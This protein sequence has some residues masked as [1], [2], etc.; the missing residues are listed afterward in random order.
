MKKNNSTK[1][2]DT[3]KIFNIKLLPK[4]KNESMSNS[5]RRVFKGPVY[6]AYNKD[7]FGSIP[8]S[9]ENVLFKAK[10][11]IE[12]SKI[13]KNSIKIKKDLDVLIEGDN[14]KYSFSSRLPKSCSSVN[15]FESKELFKKKKSKFFGGE[16][17]FDS[18]KSEITKYYPGPGEYDPDN[19]KPLFTSNRYHS[20]FK[21]N[22]D[23]S[24]IFKEKSN[25]GPGSYDPYQND[26]T[27]GKNIIFLKEKKF[28][29]LNGPF[30]IKNNNTRVGPGYINLPSGFQIKRAHHPSYFFMKET[31]GSMSPEDKIYNLTGLN[32]TR[33]RNLIN[34]NNSYGQVL[35][36]KINETKP[37]WIKEE[38]DK[39]MK[40]I[41][42]KQTES[43]NEEQ[44]ELM[45]KKNLIKYQ[46]EMLKYAM[47]TPKGKKGFTFDL[48][49]R[50]NIFTKNHVPGPSYYDH[51]NILSYLKN[52]K[53]NFHSK[54]STIWL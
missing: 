5:F 42:K 48:S 47:F 51:N 9:V 21:K 15:L 52:K 26:T 33:S 54:N 12:I 22:K 49:P 27:K 6:T 11:K 20:L 50:G 17:R 39:K 2:L 38:L 10:D 14:I 44:K 53:I 37:V 13:K 43:I 41:E 45:R 4:K 31:Q 23:E 3:Q 35:N 30:S 40:E 7:N 24:V 46:R 32:L 29:D 25:L 19:L 8:S 28:N 18:F 1:C 34:R 36:Q 16:T